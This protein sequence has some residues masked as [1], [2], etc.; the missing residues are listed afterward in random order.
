MGGCRRGPKQK[1]N[2]LVKNILAQIDSIKII[3]DQS[4][5]IAKLK[6]DTIIIEIEKGVLKLPDS[7]NGELYLLS[8]NILSRLELL[9]EAKKSYQKAGFFFD[10]AGA[11]KKLSSSL[12]NLGLTLSYLYEYDSA[13]VY[14]NKAKVIKSRLNDTLGLMNLSN[15]YAVLYSLQGKYDKAVDNLFEGLFFA[16]LLM[17]TILISTFLHNIGS[18]Y[19]ILGNYEQSIYYYL[20]ASEIDEYRQNFHSMAETY[21][22]LGIAYLESKKNEVALSYFEKAFIMSAKTK[23]KR[24]AYLSLISLGTINIS[25]NK[26]K[27]AES[28]L[29]MALDNLEDTSDIVKK[30]EFYQIYAD[31]LLKQG[32]C[33]EA[34]KILK[35]CLNYDLKEVS[36]LLLKNIYYST[37]SMYFNCGNYK[38]ALDYYVKFTN[39]NDSLKIVETKKLANELEVKYQTKQKEQENKILQIEKVRKEQTIYVLYLIS[40]TFVVSGVILFLLYKKNRHL[41]FINEA[42][43]IELRKVNK[44]LNKSLEL[45]NKFQAM[46][47]HELKNS[48]GSFKNISQMLMDRL[49][50]IQ[51]ERLKLFIQELNKSAI[52]T[53]FLLENL[54]LWSISQVY[55][56][57]LRKEQVVLETLIHET[58]ST[59]EFEKERKNIQIKTAIDEK[60]VLN[61][62]RRLFVSA[63]RNLVSNA[64]KFSPNNSVLEISSERRL[65]DN[66]QFFVIS[67][68]DQGLGL[69]EEEILIIKNSE[70]AFSNPGTMGETGSGI[71][72]KLV[73]KLVEA[74]NGFV[75]FESQQGSYTKVSIFIPEE[76]N[77]N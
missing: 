57:E 54:L 37:Y 35:K 38:S 63:F 27:E 62:D 69:T 43:N 55:N 65:I 12:M 40:S 39:L 73:M 41:A 74:H 68:K 23:N 71:G 76:I 58:L 32:K 13:L 19:S 52:D 28:Y 53:Y 11:E 48:I 4:T 46:L 2:L 77:A 34:K 50:N 29:K 3:S 1:E 75:E 67:V 45:R 22:N 60:I 42:N 30:V 51:P 24:I 64:L 56:F 7:L 72:L 15:N 49:Q 6:L 8:G 26:F 21:Y 47:S 9:N 25:S 66:K 10:K 18:V 17:D 61:I 70:I 16:K 33:F 36:P 59:F 5:E 20:K 31:L 44:E 14:Y